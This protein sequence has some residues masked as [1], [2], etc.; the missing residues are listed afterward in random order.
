MNRIDVINLLIRRGNYSRYLEIGCQSDV[1]FNAVQAPIKVGVDP[2]SGGTIR[3]RSDNFFATNRDTFDIVF[4][5]GDHHHDQVARDVDNALRFLGPGGT[6]VMH[7]C[8]PPDADHESLQRC[9]TA[10]RAF[11]NRTRTRADVESFCGDFDYGVGIVRR[12]PN[13]ALVQV[14]SMNDLTYGD[15][16]THRKAWM[17]PFD[18]H[19][20][21]AI[22]NAPNWLTGPILPP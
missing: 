5:D 15:L 2:V 12:L 19:A 11:L 14:A 4:I 3:D 20:I 1:A 8:L 10:W 13:S 18:A 6:I 17:R 7:D 9:G 21:D 16:A 22:I